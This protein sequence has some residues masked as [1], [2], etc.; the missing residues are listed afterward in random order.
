LSG[1]DPPLEGALERG[2]VPDP[3][4]VLGEKDFG[5]AVRV[6]TA[7]EFMALSARVAELEQRLAATPLQSQSPYL[8]VLEAAELLRCK[9]QRV[10][11]LLSQRR[12]SRYKDG[13]RTLVS[14]AELD[15]YLRRHCQ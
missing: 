13:S 3:A 2:S 5:H 11:D 12:L 7:E 1:S 4:L 10:D 6:P 14:R 15:E 8:T 9:R